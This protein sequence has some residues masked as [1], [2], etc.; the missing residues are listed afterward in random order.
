M[1]VLSAILGLAAIYLLLAD[2]VITSVII[3]FASLFLWFRE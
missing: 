3:L 1:K 2:W